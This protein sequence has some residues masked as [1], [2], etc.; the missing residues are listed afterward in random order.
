M[1]AEFYRK[2]TL[3]I[4][5]GA[6]VLLINL[7]L[8]IILTLPKINAEAIERNHLDSVSKQVDE[9][10]RDLDQRQSLVEKVNL[11]LDDLDRFY[12]EELGNRSDKITAVL[13]ERE[14]IS[15]RYGVLPE[16]VRYNNSD[17]RNLP[18][19]QFSMSFPLEGT[20]ASLR[21]FLNN[22]EH[23]S[24]FF[25]VENVELEDEAGSETSEMT[26][27][28]AI[29]TYFYNPDFGKDTQEDND[30]GDEQLEGEEQ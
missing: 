6:L 16:R 5:I 9:L 19:E 7:A 25:I 24:N 13:K 22:I 8:F 11:T 20:Y 29:S 14:E 23:S 4:A 12:L 10:K 15:R 3:W 1:F 2:Y 17:V 21:F 30:E 26:M 18:L 28:I 27:R